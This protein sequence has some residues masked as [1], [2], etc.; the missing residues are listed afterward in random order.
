MREVSVKC[1][2]YSIDWT[3]ES[4]SQREVILRADWKFCIFRLKSPVIIISFTSESTARLI[5]SSI[6]EKI[7][8][9]WGVLVVSSLQLKWLYMYHRILHMRVES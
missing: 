8:V 5:E 7:T 4:C 3:R 6:A 2:G 9:F 1:V